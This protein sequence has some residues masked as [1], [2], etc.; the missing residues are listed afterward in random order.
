MR[1][2]FLSLLLIFAHLPVLAQETEI[3]VYEPSAA[4]T[5][6]AG[7]WVAL[8]RGF[9]GKLRVQ[10]LQTA[11]ESSPIQ[12]VVT[13]L[14]EGNIAFGVA[15]PDHIL[16]A[17]EK[18]HI[19]LVAV[20]ADFQVGAMRII[21]WKPIQ[22]AKDLAGKFGIWNGCQARARCAVQKGWQ[23]VFVV[24]QQRGDINPWLE[25]TWP[26]A[27]A[28][29]YDELI[30]AQREAKRMGKTFYTIDYRD[31]GIDWVDH[32][33]FTTEDVITKHPDI[34]QAV[35]HGR[36][37]GFR[38]AFENFSETI[39]ILK[40]TEKEL[41]PGRETDALSS[42]KLLMMTPET[43]R[44]GL[45]YV[46]PKKWERMARDLFKAG[47]LDRIPDLKNVFTEKFASGVFP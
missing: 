1:F 9:F 2:S 20:S 30:A 6:C 43:K 22:S 40:K 27:S 5:E 13:S 4:H 47:L 44:Y 15:H 14:Q 18:E 37:R 34:V 28:M 41:S 10:V 19:K 31:L 29:T 11:P 7:A 45:G 21:S 12:D 39:E 38:W 32:V 35:V 17:R 8:E 26:L 42:V 23:R 25:G 16:T 3:R 46:Q 33:L 36:Y 24:Q